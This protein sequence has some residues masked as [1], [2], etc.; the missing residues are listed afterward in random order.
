MSRKFGLIGFP[1][2]HSFSRVY[3][4]ERFARL[5]IDAVYDNYEISDIAFLRAIVDKDDE[6][7]GLNV[8]IPHKQS[9]I[10]L[11]D[12]LDVTAQVVGAVNVIRIERC[13]DCVRMVGY[14]SDCM[15]FRK[16]LESLLSPYH[17]HAL[18]LGTGGASKAVCATLDSLGLIVSKV[19]R[20]PKEGVLS[21][22]ALTPE[23]M[24]LH[25][26]IVN[27]TPLGMFPQIDTCPPIPYEL[28]TPRHLCYDVV[29]NPE[30]TLF[31]TRAAKY[32]AAVCNGLKM[33]IEQADAA[34]KIWN[35]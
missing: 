14:N 28:L 32:G 11:L 3:H 30:Q 4:N 25:K 34:C 6:L 35:V 9:V 20:T 19:S 12:E 24:A 27:T 15:G 31:M 7:E 10:P 18:V 16:S 13:Y 21:Y 33:L 5:G 26:L 17:T 29:Y 23:V 2:Q 1:L 22:D 8:T